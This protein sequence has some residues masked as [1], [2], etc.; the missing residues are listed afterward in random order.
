MAGYGIPTDQFDK[1]KRS[2]HGVLLERGVRG[3]P[4][5]PDCHGNHGAAPPGI[6]SVSNICGQCHP[7]NREL[8]AQSPHEKPFEEMGLAGCKTCHGHHDIQRPTDGIL[9]TEKGSVCISCH[10]AGSGGYRAAADMRGAIER[11]KAKQE[12]AGRLLA[13]AEQAGMEVSQARFDLNEV[14]NALTKSRASVHAFS[15]ARLEEV[16]GQGEA[17]ADTTIWKGERALAEVQAR[18]RGFAGFLVVLL[19]VGGALFFKIRE[20]DRREGI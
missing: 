15:A 7:A 2:V 1:Y 8:L 18:R 4:A 5:C 3:A 6:H 11:L 13:R 12:T 9:G 16:V 20:V 14:G 10:Q 19:A 17:L